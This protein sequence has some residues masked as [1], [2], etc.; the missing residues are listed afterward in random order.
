MTVL[1]QPVERVISIFYYQKQG[2]APFS[3]NGKPVSFEEYVES[4]CDLN[5][6]DYQVRVLSGSPDLD[7][8]EYTRGEIVTV[9]AGGASSSGAGQAQHL[10]HFLTVAPLERMTDVA[11][12]L[13]KIYG[14][15]M[16]RI[17][18]E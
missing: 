5:L 14:W 9:P 3:M 15:P 1:R 10:E 13:R 17:Q 11:L 4:R 18:S 6:L 16:R 8:P 7:R 2:N 12:M